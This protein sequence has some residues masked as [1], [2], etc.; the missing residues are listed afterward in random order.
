MKAWFLCAD[1]TSEEDWRR[2][3]DFA[4]EK[5]GRVD[6]LINNAGINI[7]KPVEEMSIDEWMTMMQ[8]NT[9]STFPG[10][11]IRHTGDAQTGRRRD[12]QYLLRVRPDRT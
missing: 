5:A 3:I 7:R 12:Y 1:V 8:V 10:L 9:G 4:L 11:Q 2:A 6:V